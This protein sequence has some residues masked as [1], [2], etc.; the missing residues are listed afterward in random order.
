MVLFINSIN[1]KN[2]YY[3]SVTILGTG[4]VTVSKTQA[5]PSEILTPYLSYTFQLNINPINRYN[6]R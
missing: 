2:T 5:L 6:I 3:M 1:L 4:D